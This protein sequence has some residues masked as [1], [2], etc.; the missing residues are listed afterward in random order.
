[1]N[2]LSRPT[3]IGLGAIAIWATLALFTAMTGTMPPF[4]TTAICFALGG[5][6]I[7]S[8]A[9]FRRDWAKLKPTLPAFLLGLYGPFGDTVIYFAALKLAPPASV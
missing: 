2:A 7:V 9:V 8:P 1:M 3:F 4:L 5:L 6:V